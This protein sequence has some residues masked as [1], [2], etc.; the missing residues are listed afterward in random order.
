MFVWVCATSV[1]VSA[2]C[3]IFQLCSCLEVLN[4]NYVRNL[5]LNCPRQLL[6]ENIGKFVTH[7]KVKR[8]LSHKNRSAAE[9]V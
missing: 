2:R 6:Y 7:R 3:F 4:I 5:I 8:E 1:C 9:K